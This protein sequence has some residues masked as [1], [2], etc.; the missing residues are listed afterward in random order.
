MFQPIAAF[1]AAVAAMALCAT[2]A[3]SQVDVL[4]WT[5]EDTGGLG[6]GIQSAE[7]LFISG[8][9]SEPFAENTSFF[10]A[11]APVD[12]TL[13]A[14]LH[15]INTDQQI[16]FDW[17]AYHVDGVVTK[18]AN[19]NGSSQ[20]LI[21]LLH[22]SAGQSFGLG[23][24]SQDSFG[25][26]L[27]ATFSEILFLPDSPDTV[28]VATSGGP[29]DGFA[30]VLAALGDVNG[31]GVP[32]MA[33]GAPDADVGAADSG[34]VDLLSG[35]DGSS[36]GTLSGA[37]PGD[38][39]GA[40]LAGLGDVDGDGVPDFAVGAPLDDAAGQDAGAVFVYSGADLSLIRTH[41]AEAAND[42]FG[43]SLAAVDDT[44]GD[45][46]NDLLVG[47]PLNDELANKAGKAQLFSGADGALLNEWLGAA[48]RD[49]FGTTV[50]GLHDVDGDGRG[51][52]A[53]GAPS[54]FAGALPNAGMVAVFS[55]A[56]GAMLWERYGNKSELQMGISIAG[57]GDIDDDG[58]A[59]VILGMPRLPFSSG[60]RV[61]VRSGLDGAPIHE[62]PGFPFLSTAGTNEGNSGWAVGDPGDVDGDGRDDFMYSAKLSHDGNAFHQA[63]LIFS[64]RTGEVIQF[65]HSGAVPDDF[66][67]G[68]GASLVNLGDLDA[69]GLPEI[70]VGSSYVGDEFPLP[71]RVQM[72]HLPI[73][74]ADLGQGLQ[75][76]A[77]VPALAG[78][79]LLQSGLPWSL[80]LTELAPLSSTGLVIGLAT[81][82]APFKS[83][84]LV[85][86]LDL[87][88]AGLPTD[89]AGELTLAG[90]WPA[91]IPAGVH[92]WVQAWTVDAV[93]PAGLSAS[94]AVRATTR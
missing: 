54:A 82:Y 51:D 29:D 11:Q 23:V 49:E 65:L 56:S 69:D 74:W 64:G 72:F 6:F 5:F 43:A 2:S 42:H 81:L 28:E 89:A 55:G 80:R 77:G 39:F 36:L 71:G 34:R 61:E 16:Q 94:N 86:S 18:L 85:P 45:G 8:P 33:V 70:A 79:G 90:S 60:D 59:D 7:S 92:F 87:L 21:F 20:E 14:R 13:T 15:W 68:F 3:S 35:A 25:G 53:V 24:K 67:P 37:G 73:V 75:G 58:L 88:L 63:V 66:D 48:L 12:G 44:D 91:G 17:A 46:R 27:I 50:A 76:V 38:R 93:A 57:L 32:D 22:V 40:A 52:V 62:I 9:D 83:G 30:A 31:D 4:D 78:A 10:S 19:N 26:E 84:V 41:L 47:A 1:L